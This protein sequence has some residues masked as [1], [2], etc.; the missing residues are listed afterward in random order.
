MLGEIGQLVERLQVGHEKKSLVKRS[1]DE[2][3]VSRT[4]QHMM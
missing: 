1:V 2:A 4:M 3:K